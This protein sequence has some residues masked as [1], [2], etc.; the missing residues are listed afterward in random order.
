MNIVDAERELLET[1]RAEA[2]RRL[3]R[4]ARDADVEAL[5]QALYEGPKRCV[6]DPET[7]MERHLRRQ[8]AEGT[9]EDIARYY[10]R[11]A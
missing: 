6:N 5:A 10:G 1:M 9:R 7:P 11:R 4:G 8:T 3:G 2:V